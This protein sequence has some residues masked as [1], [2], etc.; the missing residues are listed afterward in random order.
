LLSSSACSLYGSS[1]ELDFY[2]SSKVL[3]LLKKVSNVLQNSI[4]PNW[5]FWLCS[6]CSSLVAN[7]S[8][9]NFAF[10]LTWIA[11]VLAF[12]CRLLPGDIAQHSCRCS[13]SVT[14]F[15]HPF[16]IKN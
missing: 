9:L 13:L 11:F 8:A 10:S 2:Y 12:I 1:F 16:I 6:K 15:S 7:S 3:L 14:L 4:M 5:N